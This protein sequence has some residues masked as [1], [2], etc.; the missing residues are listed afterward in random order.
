MSSIESLVKIFSA[1]QLDKEF[2]E[3]LDYLE[4]FAP[5]WIHKIRNDD[6]GFEDSLDLGMLDLESR[7]FCIVG[8][9]YG[10]SSDYTS[11]TYCKDHADY[12]YRHARIG[13]DRF[14]VSPKFKLELVLLAFHWKVHLESG[15]L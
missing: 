1:E 11:C 7:E 5:K 14:E 8:E 10:N 3:A 2:N 13:I 12:L 6:L 9:L 15:I 4:Q